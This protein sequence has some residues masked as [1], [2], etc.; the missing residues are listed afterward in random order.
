MRTIVCSFFQ[1]FC[2]SF[3][4]WLR[5]AVAEARGEW[6]RWTRN[7]FP[8][9]YFGHRTKFGR[10]LKLCGIPTSVSRA[11]QCVLTPWRAIKHITEWCY[12]QCHQG[13][14]ILPSVPAF[15]PHPFS[16]PIWLISSSHIP[17]LL[18]GIVYY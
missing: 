3:L 4:P 13:R 2:R 10:T 8:V 6:T 5:D 14:T 7:S 11:C 1:T 12:T 9:T 18:R 16:S 17:T 15:L